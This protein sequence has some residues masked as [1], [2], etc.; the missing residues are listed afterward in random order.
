MAL[1]DRDER[2][3]IAYE[4]ASEVLEAQRETLSE[5]DAKA[6]RTVRTTVVLLG[7]LLSA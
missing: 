2:R 6:V 3:E 4:A 1:H 5:V 7:V